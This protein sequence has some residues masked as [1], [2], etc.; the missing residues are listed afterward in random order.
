MKPDA[1]MMTRSETEPKVFDFVNLLRGLAAI[2]VFC[3]H[4]V[5]HIL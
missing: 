2:E 1:T 3:F 4:L 5:I